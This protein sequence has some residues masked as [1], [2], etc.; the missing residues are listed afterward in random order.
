MSDVEEIW[1]NCTS[2]RRLESKAKSAVGWLCV[3]QA[4]E[5]VHVVSQPHAVIQSLTKRK[6]SGLFL[7]P[8]WAPW[9]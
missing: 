8:S 9:S 2:W 3:A 6:P 5:A 1:R 7:G 4:P